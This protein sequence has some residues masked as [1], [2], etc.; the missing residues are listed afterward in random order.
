MLT[1]NFRAVA[2]ANY[3]FTGISDF[4]ISIVSFFIMK[5]VAEAKSKSAMFGYA[6]GGACGSLIA[7]FVT[8]IIYGK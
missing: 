8:K 5:K 7:I 1:I 4:I 6:L 2:Q 3:L